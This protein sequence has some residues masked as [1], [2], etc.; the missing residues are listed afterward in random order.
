[1]K[2]VAK[3]L[4]VDKDDRYLL[5]YR[6]N[7]P[8]FPNDPDLPGG[9]LE[10]NEKSSHS[11]IRELSEETGIALDAC[12]LE[13]LY[14]SRSYDKGYIYYLY[15]AKL[16]NHPQVSISWEHSHFEWLYLNDF[17]DKTHMAID[18]YM[19]MVY[20]YLSQNNS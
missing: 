7:H 15:R 19:Q 9:T 5:L 20:D 17:I 1:M 4:L 16:D 2:R 10:D 6:S 3:L 14:A 18:Q 13:K 12:T 11:V 8:S